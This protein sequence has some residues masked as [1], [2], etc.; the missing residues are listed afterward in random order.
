MR[1]LTRFFAFVAWGLLPSFAAADCV[2][3]LHGLA[4]SETSFVV[5]EQVLRKQG[6]EV[7][8]P[9]YESTEFPVTQL[10]DQVLPAA[11]AACQGKGTLHFVTHSM[12]AIL[13]RHYLKEA[14]HR[15][16]QLGRT[17]MLG[18]P[19]RGSELVDELGDWAIFGMI[20]GPAGQSLGTGPQSLPGQLPPADFP[21]G[22]I[23]G[24]QSISPVFSA[25]IPGAD[26]GKVSVESTRLDGMQDHLVLPVTHTFMMNDPL[27]IAQV[28]AF[29]KEGRF[30]QSITWMEALNNAIAGSCIGADCGYGLTIE[31]Q[32]EPMRQ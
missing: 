22:I 7:L 29:L 1:N 28:V 10:A 26:D 3:L 25:L 11:V 16:A 12:G 17:V 15:P 18:P 13:L 14:A 6:Y 2:V 4:R 32:Q 21:L 27:V 9:G 20:N 24:S 19:N 23:A 5:M 31:K 8:R 30:D